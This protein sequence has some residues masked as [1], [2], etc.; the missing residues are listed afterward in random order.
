MQYHHTQEQF[1]HFHEKIKYWV[2]LDLL[3]GIGHPLWNFRLQGLVYHFSQ[4]VQRIF[5]DEIEMNLKY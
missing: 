2:L 1:P 5:E 3:N 4:V